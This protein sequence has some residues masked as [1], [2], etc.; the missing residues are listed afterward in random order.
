MLLLL[1]LL[2]ATA[3]SLLTAAISGCSLSLSAVVLMAGQK[4][5]V[6]VIPDPAAIDAIMATIVIGRIACYIMRFSLYIYYFMTTMA[7][8]IQPVLRAEGAP[9][10]CSCPAALSW[11]HYPPA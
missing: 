9:A 6:T 3:V 5:R 1:L 8:T 10:A 11:A 2:P 7:M 4:N